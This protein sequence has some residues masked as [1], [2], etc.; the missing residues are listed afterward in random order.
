M[1]TIFMKRADWQKWDDAL[2]SGEYK[3]GRNK[4]IDSESETPRYCCLGVLE[5]VLCGT[6]ED[7]SLP[8]MGWLGEHGVK[9][10]KYNDSLQARTP[11]IEPYDMGTG[12]M[13]RTIDGLNDSGISFERIADVIKM[14]VEFT[15]E[16]VCQISPK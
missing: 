6:V 4:L 11:D 9:F 12:E 13:I 15:D 16:D 2:R 10:V 3:Q 7:I 14:H 1:K 5:Q 8:T